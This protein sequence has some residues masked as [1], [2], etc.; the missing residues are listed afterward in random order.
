M[1]S[2]PQPSL[3]AR[4]LLFLTSLK[5][6]VGSGGANSPRSVLGPLLFNIIISDKDDGIKCT[7]SKFADDTNLSSAVD[8]AEGRDAIQRDLDKLERWAHVNLRS[9]NKAKYKVLHLD[10][11]NPTY[12]YSL[13]E[14][15]LEQYLP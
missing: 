7:L 15:H 5:L 6:L 13:G 1:N 10:W 4:I 3:A 2:F 9:F 12:L 8:T 11:G 14:E